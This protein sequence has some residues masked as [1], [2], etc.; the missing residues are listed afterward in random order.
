MLWEK[1]QTDRNTHLSSKNHPLV[2]INGGS[3]AFGGRSDKQFEVR[4]RPSVLRGQVFICGRTILAL[5]AWHVLIVVIGRTISVSGLR[6]ELD[7]YR[8]SC[9]S[10]ASM[11]MRMSVIGKSC[12]LWKDVDV[13]LDIDLLCFYLLWM[14]FSF[15]FIFSMR[16]MMSNDYC[17]P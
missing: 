13:V 1:C 7:A 14:V 16:M 17:E 8:F 6:N 11:W 3:R 12:Y 5:G 2:C 15:L 10:A 4:L 9:S